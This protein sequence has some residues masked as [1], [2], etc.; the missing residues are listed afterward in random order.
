MSQ[1]LETPTGKEVIFK[2][3]ISRKEDRE[4]KNCL[5]AGIKSTSSGA[6]DQTSV[7]ENVEK[8]KDLLVTSFVETYAGKEISAA[9]V[10]DMPTQDYNFCHEQARKIYDGLDEKK[11]SQ[12]SK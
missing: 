2:E 12:A 3:T 4:I 11:S 8:Q 1:K 7:V 10:D 6:M 9:V 5:F